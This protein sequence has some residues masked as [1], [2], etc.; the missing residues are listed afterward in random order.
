MATSKI[1]GGNLKANWTASSSS[2]T[3]TSLTQSLTLTPGVW[4]VAYAIP[5]YA[6]GSGTIGQVYLEGNDFRP[7]D[8]AYQTGT[9]IVSATS[10]K[11]ISVKAGAGA[12]V[13]WNPEYLDRGGLWAAKLM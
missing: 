5:P 2:A 8:K 11:T 13:S 1:S 6:S 7:A 3:G 4:L 9:W 10:S 12:S